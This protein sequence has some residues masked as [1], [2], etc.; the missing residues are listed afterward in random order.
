MRGKCLKWIER[1]KVCGWHALTLLNS[2]LLILFPGFGYSCV[3][4][5]VRVGGTEQR[6]NWQQ[7]CSYLKRRTP[8]ICTHNK[9]TLRHEFIDL[10][11]VV[12]NEDDQ[13]FIKLTNILFNI[14]IIVWVG[15]WGVG[16][17]GA[18]LAFEP[19]GF[20]S[21]SKTETDLSHLTK[22]CKISSTGTNPKNG[23]INS[24]L[25]GGAWLSG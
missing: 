25:G 16:G 23:N 7:H 5:I 1:V 18:L 2:T 10:H 20:E 21:K 9:R 11:R 15:G 12:A 3:Q 6:L 14:P 19:S 13:H 8:F 24:K 22:F 17:G 4:G